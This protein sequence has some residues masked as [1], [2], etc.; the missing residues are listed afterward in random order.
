MYQHNF[1]E[2]PVYFSELLELI[3][4]GFLKLFTLFYSNYKWIITFLNNY[5]FYCNAV[6]LYKK[7]KTVEAIKSIFQM[8][9]NTTFHSVKRLYT[10]NRSEYITSEL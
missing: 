10:D 7:Y 4:L 9:S 3:H 1:S 5:S 8:W 2:N 6:F